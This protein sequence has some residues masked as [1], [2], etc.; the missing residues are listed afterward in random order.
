ME[1]PT[2]EAEWLGLLALAAQRDIAGVSEFHSDN[3][4]VMALRQVL[5]SDLRAGVFLAPSVPPEPVYQPSLDLQS[6]TKRSG[7]LSPGI[8]RAKLDIRGSVVSLEWWREMDFPE[9]NQIAEDTIKSWRYR[10]ALREGVFVPA[11]LVI[12]IKF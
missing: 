2:P 10:P 3:S 1:A 4:S 5:L 8:V 9:V 7:T 12:T 11:E 6:I